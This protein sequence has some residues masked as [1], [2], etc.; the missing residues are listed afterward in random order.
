MS[1]P[2]VPSVGAVLVL[3]AAL[4]GLVSPVLAAE[5]VSDPEIAA[6]RQQVFENESLQVDLPGYERFCRKERSAGVDSR[7]TE[8]RPG[9][10]QREFRPPPIAPAALGAATQIFQ[11]ALL[12]LGAVVLVLVLVW[13]IQQLIAST[14]QRRTPQVTVTE[15]APEADA[16]VREGADE[17]LDLLVHRGDYGAAIHLLLLRA[18]RLLGRRG[19]RR[20]AAGH[21]SREVLASTDLEPP[22][23]GALGELVAAVERFLFGGRELDAD[24]FSRCREAF[25]VVERSLRATPAEEAS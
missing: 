14:G 16:P 4:A 3:A 12:A 6:R 5:P 15:K 2:R 1:P 8:L 11:W 22:A 7:P 20:I 19:S 21:T 10:R 25:G 17:D 9:E 18:V 13:L 23:R 24:D